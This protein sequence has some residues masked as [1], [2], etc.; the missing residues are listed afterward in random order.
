MKTSFLSAL[1][2]TA[3]A[4]IGQELPIVAEEQAQPV[5]IRGGVASLSPENT[6]ISFVGTHEGPKPDP[7]TG[8]FAAFSGKV[9]VNEGSTQV[10]SIQFEIATS[11]LRTE[12]PK[13][14]AHLKSPDFFDVR[15]H[16]QA[17]FHSTTINDGS[18][19][20][21]LDVSGEFRLLGVTQE[22]SIPATVSVTDQGLT[23]NSV[24]SLDRRRFG[25][26]YGQGRV[27]NNVEIRVNIGVPTPDVA[28]P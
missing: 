16:P 12:I 20:G 19:D 25:M 1:L 28:V 2:L 26:T 24:F 17:E 18:Q 9:E 23:L 3:A 6:T 5:P 15:Q 7:R 21:A 11:S 27:N 10:Q 13:L 14:T 8:G 22:V 4:A